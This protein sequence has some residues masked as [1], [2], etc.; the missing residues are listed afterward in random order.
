MLSLRLP[1]HARECLCI[2]TCVYEC[3]FE[4]MH[5]CMLPF[6]SNLLLKHGNPGPSSSCWTWPSDA[7]HPSGALAARMRDGA[8]QTCR[9]S[10]GRD[11]QPMRSPPSRRAPCATTQSRLC[12]NLQL[13]PL[14]RPGRAHRPDGRCC[15]SAK[16][17]LGRIFEEVSLDSES[18]TPYKIGEDAAHLSARSTNSH[19]QIDCTWYK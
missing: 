10:T 5:A 3:M 4:C 15:A 8:K 13:G 9:R 19:I 11:S 1:V 12:V 6:P 18:T 16:L 14:Q 7:Q 17:R 2:G